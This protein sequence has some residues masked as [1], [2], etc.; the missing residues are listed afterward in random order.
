M[1]LWADTAVD[2]A[3]CYDQRVISLAGRLL[4]SLTLF[5]LEFM[6][7]IPRILCQSLIIHSEDH[8]LQLFFIHVVL[9][10]VVPSLDFFYYVKQKLFLS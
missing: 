6:V 8:L 2:G 10:V 7:L 9:C 4:E 3:P 1:I 5:C